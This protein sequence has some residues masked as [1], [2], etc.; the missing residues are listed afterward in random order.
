MIRRHRK[1]SHPATERGP[2]RAVTRRC[3]LPKEA[4]ADI[5]K[6]VSEALRIDARQ[7]KIPAVHWRCDHDRPIFFVE[8]RERYVCTWCEMHD[9]RLI[10]IASQQSNRRAQQV[11]YPTMRP[12]SVES[13][14][15]PWISWSRR[16]MKLERD[17]KSSRRK[18]E[19]RCLKL[20]CRF[21]NGS[22]NLGDFLIANL[23]KHIAF[24]LG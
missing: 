11:R 13:Q 23:A 5:Q 9:G 1:R 3:L 10:L 14:D 17:L 15:S 21:A 24:C 7:K 4:L 12:T 8:L 16:K 20:L 2:T 6:I 22:L 19:F 18:I